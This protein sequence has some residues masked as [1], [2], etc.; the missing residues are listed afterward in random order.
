M[1]SDG[2]TRSRAALGFLQL[3]EAFEVFAD[4][5]DAERHG[6]IEAAAPADR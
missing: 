3:P 6:R 1:C 5:F 2:P 4:P